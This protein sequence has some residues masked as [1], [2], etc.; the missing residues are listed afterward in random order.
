MKKTRKYLRIG[1]VTSYNSGELTVLV[2]G[3]GGYKSSRRRQS[4]LAFALI[5]TDEIK[6]ALLLGYLLHDLGKGKNRRLNMIS[7][8]YLCYCVQMY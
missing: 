2:G 6:V 8:V 7:K 3:G 5:F 4:K 1:K